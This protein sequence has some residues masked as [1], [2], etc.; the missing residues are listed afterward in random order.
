MVSA[1]YV[2]ALDFFALVRRSFRDD[3]TENVVRG[4]ADAG[5]LVV[6]EVDKGFGSQTEFVYLYQLVNER[7]N[8]MLPTV[9]VTNAREDELASVIGA[10]T[11]SRVAGEGAI[12]NLSGPDYR[13]RKTA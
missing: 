4:F 8:R 13:Q 11:L 7:Y 2:V 1:R 10:S 3:S 5:Y 9:L 6:D 12:I